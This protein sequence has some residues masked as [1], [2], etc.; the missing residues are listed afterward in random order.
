MG[1][2]QPSLAKGLSGPPLGLRVILSVSTLVHPFCLCVGMREPRQAGLQ[3]LCSECE[4]CQFWVGLHM[5]V[6][7]TG[8][9][10][11]C[12]P[13]PAWEVWECHLG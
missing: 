13:L 3:G 11:R 10:V 4:G 7:G 1:G 8:E 12:E 6:N 2:L 5:F 9:G